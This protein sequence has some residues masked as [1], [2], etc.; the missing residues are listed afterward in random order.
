[1]SD[2]RSCTS[3]AS[4][5]MIFFRS[6]STSLL[7]AGGVFADDDGVIGF[8][9]ALEAAGEREDFERRKLGAIV[10]DGV[11]AGP[12]DGAENVDDAGVRDGDDVAG[13]D[14]DVVDHVAGF[15]NL[16]EVDGDGVDERR[17]NLW[18]LGGGLFGP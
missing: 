14:D 17:R 13:L 11:A 8:G 18:R 9:G 6:T 7:L 1:M 10:G 4:N 2:G 15:E 16:A 3:S 5:F 12:G